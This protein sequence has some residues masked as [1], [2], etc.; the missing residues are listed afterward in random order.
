MRKGAIYAT[1][2][3]V[4]EVTGDTLR[5]GLMVI[6]STPSTVLLQSVGYY[7]YPSNQQ[8]TTRLP[9]RLTGFSALLTLKLGVFTEMGLH[10]VY[11]GPSE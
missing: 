3:A 6:A 2:G 9:H 8:D 10:C 4:I 11:E 7:S 5:P 1:C